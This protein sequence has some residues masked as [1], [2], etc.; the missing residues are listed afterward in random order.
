[1]SRFVLVVAIAAC[2]V[3]LAAAH[4]RTSSI[5]SPDYSCWTW[6]DRECDGERVFLC[7]AGDGSW[8]KVSVRDHL[9]VAMPGCIVT[10][11]LSATCDMCLCGTVRAVTDANG[12]AYLYV[13]GGLDVSDTTLCCVATTSVQCL[14]VP[15]PYYDDG[16]SCDTT[17]GDGEAADSDNEPWLSPDLDGDCVVGGLDFSIFASDWLSGACRSDL[18]CDGTVGGLD[19]SMFAGHWLH[20]CTDCPY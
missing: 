14:A 2:A 15:I 1:M 5:P 13:C 10:A 19:F 8:M 9:N 11:D 16:C 6:Y 12:C 18:D 20:D 4:V 3:A 7:P 17:N